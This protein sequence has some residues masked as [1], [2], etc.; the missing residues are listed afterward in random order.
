[1]CDSVCERAP[2]NARAC[3]RGSERACAHTLWHSAGAMDAC[4]I[5]SGISSKCMLVPPPAEPRTP[6][7]VEPKA[8]VSALADV[9]RPRGCSSCHVGSARLAHALLTVRCS[10]GVH[11]GSVVALRHGYSLAHSAMISADSLVR[12]SAYHSADC[13]ALSLTTETGAA[14][15]C[16]LSG[17]CGQ[18]D[19]R[20]AGRGTS[21]AKRTAC[22]AQHRSA[23]QRIASHHTAQHRSASHSSAAQRSASHRIAGGLATLFV[24]EG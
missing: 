14:L 8:A 20:A 22:I 3:V 18:T 23:A 13:A 4:S 19:S 10:D 2:V 15:R 24:P 5:P 7:A 21:R 1:M 11:R 9:V 17:R 12:C 16:S 6:Y